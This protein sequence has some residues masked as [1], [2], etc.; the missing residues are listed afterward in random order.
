MGLRQNLF[1]DA[2]VEIDDPATPARD[3]FEIDDFNEEGAETTLAGSI[4]LGRK[5]LYLTDLELFG[6]FGDLGDPTIDWRNTL[7]YRLS[8]FTS[9]D[10]TLDV[11]RIPQVL[12]ENQVTQNIL[13]RFSFNIL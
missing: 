2:F 7:S 12:D 13:L 11:L 6:D 8:R 1:A 5:L 3:F 10:Y 4:R 9:L